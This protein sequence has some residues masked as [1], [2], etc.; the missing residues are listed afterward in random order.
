MERVVKDTII[1]PFNLNQYA[2]VENK[3]LQ[4]GLIFFGKT[5][6]LVEQGLCFDTL[7]LDFCLNSAGLWF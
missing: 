5:T 3:S 7:F 6:S 4:M 2:F 1:N